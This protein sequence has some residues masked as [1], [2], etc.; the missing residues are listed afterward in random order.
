MN[1]DY[2]ILKGAIWELLGIKKCLSDIETNKIILVKT[3]EKSIF[4]GRKLGIQFSAT[5]LRSY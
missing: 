4:R 1:F 3:F 2:S 5:Q